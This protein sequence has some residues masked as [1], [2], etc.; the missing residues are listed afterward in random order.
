VNDALFR[1]S[2][3]SPVLAITWLHTNRAGYLVS[4][5]GE[6]FTASLSATF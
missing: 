1:R 5:I 4:E 6:D 2:Y 3:I